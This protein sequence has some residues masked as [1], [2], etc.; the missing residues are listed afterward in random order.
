MPM[1]D[2]PPLWFLFADGNVLLRREQGR[3]VVPC[4][5]GAPLETAGM[6]HDVGLRGRR[7][8]AC[9]V[10][11]K[12]DA[13]W[14][15]VGL[16]AAYDH[17]DEA[18]Y[19]MAGKGA[20]MIHWDAHS[21]YCSFCGAQTAIMAFNAKR[22]PECGK[23]IFPVITPAVLALI[24]RDDRI[25]LA[26]NRTFRGPHYSI[27]AGFVEVGETFEECVQRE[28]WEEARL[29]VGNIRYF[30]CQPWPY[31]SGMM[32][33]FVADYQGGE[34]EFADQ[35]LIAGGFFRRDNLPELPHR[36]GLSRRMIE[37]WISQGDPAGRPA[38]GGKHC[39]RRSGCA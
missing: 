32:I 4:G 15:A 21:R 36:L 38:D 17:M 9:L 29:K 27:I 12:P 20:Q 35:E 1:R 11:E 31:P 34:P 7:A 22:C 28:A 16:R 3:L 26:R 2:D 18:C 24:S 14:E 33:G 39:G 5:L 13:G 37:W 10:R 30:G 23:E 25:F 19:L 6:L 8:T